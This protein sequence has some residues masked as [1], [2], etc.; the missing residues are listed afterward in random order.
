MTL[1]RCTSMPGYSGAFPERK[2][3]F[4]DPNPRGGK[5]ILEPIPSNRGMG[6]PT[7]LRSS[8]GREKTR[9]CPL[10]LS[11]MTLQSSRTVCPLAS[12]HYKAGGTPTEIQTPSVAARAA[13][14]HRKQ[15]KHRTIII[16]TT[17]HP[18]GRH[19][20]FARSDRSSTTSP[21]AESLPDS[22]PNLVQK[23]PAVATT[24]KAL[25][26]RSSGAREA[27]TPLRAGVSNDQ[28]K[29]SDSDGATSASSREIGSC[30][31]TTGGSSLQSPFNHRDLE[32]ELQVG[33]WR[34]GNKIGCG[35]FGCVYKAQDSES[36]RLFAVK[37]AAIQ[38]D[39]QS[40]KKD[41]EQLQNEIDICSSMR[42]PNIVNYLGSRKEGHFLCVFLEFVPGGS[43]SC[44]LT[45]F[46]ALNSK[47]L[48]VA[49]MG[50]LRGLHFLHSRSPPVVHRDLKCSNILVDL[51]FNVK[52]ADFGCSK[53]SNETK[54]FSTVGSIPWMA[55]EVIQSANGHGRKA[56]I[57]SLGCTV[58]EMA[59]AEKPWGNGMFD[60]VMSALRH[61]GM[62]D[63]LPR[64]PEEI[65]PWCKEFLSL[66]ICRD[67]GARP[68]IR[69]LMDL[70]SAILHED[71]LSNQH[72]WIP[73]R[74]Q[75]PS[76]ITG[77]S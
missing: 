16:M 13:M 60:N 73:S 6:L 8:Q 25:P 21:S 2:T 51:N 49:T 1:L 64:I 72:L 27:W 75:P 56:D 31:E 23:Q 17:E 43:M 71:R 74:S 69:L 76:S 12:P 10:H 44:V 3:L 42:H 46:G 53:R 48:S 14:Q 32:P 9:T 66:C 55:P 19:T 7:L 58:L 34:R 29:L 5:L 45:T 35:S 20:E 50:C 59:T 65:P 33:K 54:S 39:G 41:V 47:L 38:V 52:L 37:Q 4:Y 18:E 57:W 77:S 30:C 26:L 62:T 15:R 68:G 70:L 11:S 40:H 63:S 67:V 24:P 22:P 36:G 28:L 61:I